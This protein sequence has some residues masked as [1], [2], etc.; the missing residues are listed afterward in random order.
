MSEQAAK[1]VTTL[2]PADEAG[3]KEAAALLR[4]G[5]PVAVPTETVYGLA[6]DA[7]NAQAVA[8]IYAAKGRPDFNPL[9]VHVPDIAHARRLVAFNPVAEMLAAKFWPGALTLVLPSNPDNGIA[10]IVTAGLPTLAVRVPAHPVM[11]TLLELMG[12]P[13]AAPSANVS[14]TLSPTRAEH[15]MDSLSTKIPAI[16]NGGKCA[17]GLESTIIGY[18]NGAP[19]LLRAGAISA[20]DIALAI[21]VAPGE[22]NSKKISAPGQLLQHYA[23]RKSLRLN[24]KTA[25]A[26][27]I[28]IGFGDMVC[29][30]NLSPAADLVEAASN[31]F[32]MLHQADHIHGTTIAVAAIPQIGLGVAI[33]DRLKRAATGPFPETDQLKSQINHKP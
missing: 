16:V 21:S 33:N 7:T 11:Q 22:P 27:E 13:L 9:I 17:K 2:L 23:P 28:V 14:G 12:K 32:D 4:S 10:G 30:L 8:R 24:A 19:V 5:Q 31:L 29:T 6:A 1:F 18:E 3:L 20:E 25:R 26:D 15:V